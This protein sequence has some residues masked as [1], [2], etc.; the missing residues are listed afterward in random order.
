MPAAAEML[1]QHERLALLGA[2][3]ATGSDWRRLRRQWHLHPIRRR[4]Q[5]DRG[6]QLPEP[7]CSLACPR[8][9]SGVY[10]L[11]GGNLNPSS[12]YVGGNT[13]QSLYTQ[14][15]AVPGTFVQTGGAVGSFGSGTSN[16]AV[17]LSVG[18]NWTGGSTTVTAT[19]KTTYPTSTSPKINAAA[20]SYTLGDGAS[21]PLFVGGVEGVGISGTGTFTQNSGTNAIVGGGNTGSIIGN[22]D[23][24]YNNP[25]GA[26]L[27]GWYAGPQGKSTQ[28][29]VKSTKTYSLSTPYRGQAEGT[30]NL[31]GGLLTGGT[32]GNNGNNMSGFE[33]VGCGGTGIFNQSG[34]TNIASETLCVG[35]CGNYGEGIFVNPYSTTAYG[36]YSLSNGLLTTPTLTVGAAGTG[37]FT[38]DRRNQS[39]GT[40]TLGGVN[41]PVSGAAVSTPG[42]F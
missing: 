21:A 17:G 20:G 2:H 18:G 19:S 22:G 27:L 35:G 39:G 14:T 37:I 1:S 42:A 28:A 30:Y 9:L 41:L 36:T 34:G 33:V 29:Y 32:T 31:N 26:L 10:N 7:R 8:P 24:S 16:N 38:A 15:D 6:G 4:Q 5:H 23:V 25:T 12:I 3:R 11:Q 13:V 40:I